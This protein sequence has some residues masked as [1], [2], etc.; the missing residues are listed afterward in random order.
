MN[1]C[2]RYAVGYAATS[3][4]NSKNQRTSTGYLPGAPKACA[5]ADQA[6]VLPRRSFPFDPSQ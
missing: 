5:G 3:C 4:T 1:W 2:V 6:N